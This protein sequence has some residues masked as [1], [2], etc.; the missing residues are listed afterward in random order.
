MCF[1]VASIAT[2][3]PIELS[4]ASLYFAWDNWLGIY[5]ISN[6]KIHVVIL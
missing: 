1:V 3:N 6:S 2:I 4:Y 5:G